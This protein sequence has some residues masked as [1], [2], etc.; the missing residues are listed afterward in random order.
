MVGVI[1]TGLQRGTDAVE[2]PHAVV[3]PEP[4]GVQVGRRLRHVRV[5]EHVLHVVQRPAG[6]QQPTAALVAQVVEVQVDR[7]EHGA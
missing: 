6:F 7:V 4:R 2:S 3:Q 5:P 1:A